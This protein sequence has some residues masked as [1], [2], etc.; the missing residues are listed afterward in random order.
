[1]K[2]I[3]SRLIILLLLVSVIVPLLPADVHSQRLSSVE[4]ISISG[5]KAIIDCE[6]FAAGAYTLCVTMSGGWLVCTIASGAAYLGCLA[7][8]AVVAGG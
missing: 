2:K 3:A 8:N 4:M 1:M 6:T 5:G 7:A